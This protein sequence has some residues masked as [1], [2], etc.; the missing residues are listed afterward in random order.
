ME[1]FNV[2]KLEKKLDMSQDSNIIVYTCITGNYEEP[3]PHSKLED[4]IS[5]LC[6][7]DNLKSV[8][9][10]WIYKPIIG[11]EHLN[12]KDKN[13]FIKINPTKFLPKHEIS[14]YIDGNIEIVGNLNRLINNIRL[15]KEDIFFY[16]HG[17]RNCLYAEAEIIVRESISWF[18]STFK[19]IK[20]YYLEGFP[21]QVGLYEANIIIRKNTNRLTPLMKL[22]WKEYKFGSNRDQ[23]SLPYV[24]KKSS[25]NI[26]SLGKSNI[27]NGNNFIDA[28]K[29]K[30]DTKFP[31][32]QYFF[33]NLLQ[34]KRKISLWYLI[35]KYINIFFLKI[36]KLQ[37]SF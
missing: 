15:S 36:I 21:Q 17:F 30:V 31:K 35:R 25:V 11:L 13:R 32:E 26:C 37:P 27:R 2:S 23:V 33:L 28:N 6:F 24:A 18:W 4:N 8:S 12:N 34:R 9:K 29:H 5:Y 7:T 14:I 10:G 1:D 16:E 22:W 20:K 3:V 19:Q